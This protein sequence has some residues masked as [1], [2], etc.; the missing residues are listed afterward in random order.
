MNNKLNC[1]HILKPWFVVGAQ[2]LAAICGLA[3]VPQ[4][5]AADAPGWMHA[6]ASA[7]VPAHDEKTDAVVLDSEMTVTVQ[8]TD[9]VKTQVRV[10]YK[11]L[12]PD[13]RGL[14]V[15]KVHFDSRRKI[16]NL[17]G[18]CIPAQGKDYEVR[19]KEAVDV[20]LS[21]IEGSELISD[22]KERVLQIPAA[23]PGNV[24]GYE[25]EVEEQPF[26]L[27]RA[28]N[29]QL[30]IP[31]RE[32]SFTLQLPPDWEYKAAWL[33]LPEVKPWHSGTEW[34]WVVSDVKAL[35]PEEEM[36]PWN[37][38]SGQMV[39]SFFPPGGALPDKMFSNWQQMGNWYSLL[40]QAQ[41]DPSPELKQR[42]D[43]LTA[44]LTSPLDKMRALA[45]FVQKEVRYVAI[46]LGIG[47]LQP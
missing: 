5:V 28:W 17:R 21:G 38:V 41:R 24:I 34:R 4:A 14:G 23:D 33:N 13:G 6:A 40:T 1:K 22:V 8:S 20:A 25:Y 42:A 12:R 2:T 46:E 18:W 9:R 16:N 31:V 32:A 37:A 47:S 35:T 30:S 43:A 39:V 7:P 45:G 27:Q 15:V 36:P 19:D 3:A 26:T 29:P 11:I 44:G 10:A